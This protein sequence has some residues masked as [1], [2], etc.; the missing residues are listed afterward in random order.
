V[1]FAL[2]SLQVPLGL[3]TT[4]F[5]RYLEKP[6]RFASLRSDQVEELGRMGS[7]SNDEF[8]SILLLAVRNVTL[9]L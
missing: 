4:D 6:F 3:C 1:H 9:A 7:P 8:A 2:R 5:C